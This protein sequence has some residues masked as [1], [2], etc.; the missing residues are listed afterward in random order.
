MIRILKFE[1]NLKNQ[2][3]CWNLSAKCQVD[4]NAEIWVIKE[5]WSKCPN[6]MW[7]GD[8]IKTLKFEGKVGTQSKCWNLSANVQIDQNVEIWVKRQ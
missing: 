1:D 7:K 4:Q 3:K 6:L 2:S 5:D 8:S